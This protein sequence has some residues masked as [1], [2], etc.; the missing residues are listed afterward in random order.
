M[1]AKR[2]IAPT[3][4]ETLGKPV[5]RLPRRHV[6]GMREAN[7]EHEPPAVAGL[8][9][10]ARTPCGLAI[11]FGST[12]SRGRLFVPRPPST[13]TTGGGGPPL[14]AFIESP[15]VCSLKFPT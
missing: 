5:V 3:I 10:T 13:S 9:V 8:R 6:G 12:R 15:Q 11:R 1:K 2:E 7:R 4:R 14:T